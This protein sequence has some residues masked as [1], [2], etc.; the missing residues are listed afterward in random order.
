M[1]NILIPLLLTAV[2]YWQ[3]AGAATVTSLNDIGPGS[4]RSTIAAAT[5]GETINFAVTGTINLT[6]GLGISKDLNIV[7]PGADLL[8]VQRSFADGTPPFRVFLITS[9]T[10]SILFLKIANGNVPDLGGGITSS[11]SLSVVG[12]IFSGNQAGSSGGG[13]YLSVGSL[14]TISGCTF[15]GNQSANGGAVFNNANLIINNSTFFGNGDQAILNS[16]G[17]MD[18]SHCTIS[19]N[20]SGIANDST[21]VAA[22]VE[23]NNTIIA[24]NHSIGRF[25]VKG[26]FL[27]TGFN[28][29][30]STNEGTVWLASDLTGSGA[31]PLDPRLGTLQNNGG[32]APA[33]TLTMAL[34]PGSPAL[35]AGTAGGFATD[36]RTYPIR[37][38]DIAGVPNAAGGDS[39]DIGAME[40]IA[41]NRIVTTTNESG[42]GSLRQAIADTS[43]YEGDIITFA[44]NVVGDISLTTGELHVN[45]NLSITGPGSQVLSVSGN[46]VSTVFSILDAGAVIS[47]LTIRNGWAMGSAGNEEQQG[48]DGRG[49]GIY[50]QGILYVENCVLRQNRASGGAGGS[51]EAGG[52]GN[53]GK[54]MGGGIYNVGALFL[55]DCL[56]ISN[57]VVGGQGGQAGSGFAGGGGNGLGGGLCSIGGTLSLTR[58]HIAASSATGGTGGVAISGGFDSNGGQG[59]GGA[60]YSESTSMLRSCTLSHSTAVAGPGNG[61]PGSGVGGG[62]YSLDRLTLFACTVASN[63][64]TGS[65][66]D[67]GGGIHNEGI[68]TLFDCTVAGN[69]AGVGGGLSGSAFIGNTILA[70]NTDTSGNPDGSGTI[71]SRDY[72]LIQNTNGLTSSGTTTHNITGQDPLLG[73]LADYGGPTPTMAL[74]AGSPALDQGAN[75]GLKTDQRGFSRPLD[76][77]AVANAAGGNGTDIG[78]FEVDPNFR[79]V[80]LHRVGSDVGLSLMTILGRN[81]RAEH[82]NKLGS[83]S[84]TIFTNS[85][86]GNGYLL[87]VTNYAGANEPRR[88]YRGA[89]VP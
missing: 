48:F 34:L 60:L 38:Y 32:Q 2:L 51:T 75:Q 43:F 4:L 89:I 59:Y 29:I 50:N 52:A 36:Q 14:A 42:P 35:D 13:L 61:G 83:G 3:P 87:W 44:S 72:N 33:M 23:L 28:L 25:D 21:A 45:H 37:P 19:G 6:S 17:T 76:D 70:N 77:G 62:I 8:T 1:K 73:P 78:A 7:G 88:F 18:V 84:W 68:L 64:A 40:M 57:T 46:D 67:L 41:I 15:F 85:V 74:R 53:G 31:A 26:R 56:V 39:S 82:T 66:F 20:T 80:E 22:A 16:I 65:A 49:G 54:G 11:A 71:D 24:G 79:I 86:P 58:C 27:S 10:V 81:Y 63:A 5:P 69:S 30:G 9:G 12:C 55:T 47:G